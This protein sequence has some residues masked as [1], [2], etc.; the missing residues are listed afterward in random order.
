MSGQDDTGLIAV[1]KELFALKRQQ[2]QVQITLWKCQQ[3]IDL[4]DTE[5]E[6]TLT[7]LLCDAS[8]SL[9][10][11]STKL[12]EIVAE[13]EELRNRKAPLALAYAIIDALL[14]RILDTRVE[15][16]Q[17]AASINQCTVES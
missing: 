5:H 12:S 6:C 2:K 14:V 1:R 13:L 10:H 9:K 8:S 15:L 4:D 3:G 16:E 7:A 17:L 11:H